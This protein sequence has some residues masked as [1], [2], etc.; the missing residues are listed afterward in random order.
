MISKST[1][2]TSALPNAFS[3]AQL[4]Q[5]LIS[6]LNISFTHVASERITTLIPSVS[7]SQLHLY[8]L[9]TPPPEE[10]A[11]ILPAPD[12]SD[13]KASACN[14]GELGS[15]PGSGRSPGE[16][17]GNPLQYSCLENCMD[18]GAWWA[19]IHWVAKSQTR[20]SDF[21]F[22]HFPLPYQLISTW[23][24]ALLIE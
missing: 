21:T 10:E 23:E 24:F 12:G 11:P 20:L 17:N 8:P 3:L 2:Q 1:S 22:F 16:E 15:I 14:A 6:K 9:P 4:I 18:G 5:F 7:P 13:G 19:T